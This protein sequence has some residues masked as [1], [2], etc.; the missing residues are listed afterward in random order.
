MAAIVSAQRLSASQEQS[1]AICADR[2]SAHVVCSTPFG[3]TGSI[4][5]STRDRHRRHAVMCS[6][7]FG[8]T[9]IHHV[10]RCNAAVA[11]AIV[12]STPFGIT[13]IHHACS[14]AQRSWSSFVLNA[15]RH[16]RNPSRRLRLSGLATVACAQ[17]LSASQEQS[18]S[19][20]VTS[21]QLDVSSAQRLSASQE[22]ITSIAV[23]LIS[24]QFAVLNA[25]RHHRNNRTIMRVVR[26]T[27]RLV[28][29][30][31]F[32]ITGSIALADSCMRQSLAD[33]CSTPFGITGI[34][35]R[36][37]RRS[38]LDRQCSAQRL[39]ASQIH[40]RSHSAA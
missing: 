17:R 31:P 15:F 32:G 29:S 25:F 4:A 23:T 26:S 7:P 16:H 20:T 19:A 8:I 21:M 37:T 10:D 30:T 6:T 34:I 35:R 36:V 22:S 38:R 40:S 33:L 11:V 14:D 5:R 27:R 18:H 28:C 24:W 13:G 1:H 2:R 3:I 39:S 9:G 12:C